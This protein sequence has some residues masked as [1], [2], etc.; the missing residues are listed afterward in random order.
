M[1]DPTTPKSA[2]NPAL[3]SWLDPG[4][5]LDEVLFGLVMTLTFTLGAG[6]T[7]EDGPE[8]VRQLLIAARGCNVAWESSTR[9]CA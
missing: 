2:R 3:P 8:G 1:N 6:L 7:A 9:G 4:E 5:Q